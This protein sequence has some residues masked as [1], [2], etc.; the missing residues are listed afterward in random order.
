MYPK[1]KE[2]AKSKKILGYVINAVLAVLLI[3]AAV[4]LLRK[5]TIFYRPESQKPLG[6][7]AALPFL[8]RPR[9]RATAF[10]LAVHDILVLLSASS[11]ALLLTE[12][13][14]KGGIIVGNTAIWQGYIA[15]AAIFGLVY[16]FVGSIRWTTCIGMGLTLL[17]ALIDHYVTVFRGT[18]VLLSDI[19]AIGTAKNVAANYSVPV[20]LSVL[21]TLAIAVLFCVAVWRMRRAST[22]RRC[23]FITASLLLCSWLYGLQ[24]VGNSFGFWQG[25]LEYSEWYYFCRT[26]GNAIVKRP[27]GY[28]SEALT[29]ITE[30]YGG[31]KEEFRPNIIM[32]MNES[33]ADLHD[34]GDFETNEDYLPFLHSLE[35]KE[36]TITGDLLVSTFGGGTA[37]TE[38]EVLTGDTMAFLPYGSSP[39]QMYV[40]GEMPGVVSGLAAQGY[41]TV[42]LHPY[43]ATSWNRQQVYERLGFETQLYEDDFGEDDTERL[44]SYVSDRSDYYKIFEVYRYKRPDTPLFMFNVTMQNHGGY[45]PDENDNFTQTIH[46][47]GEYAGK[48][49]EVDEYLSLARESDKAIEELLA[50]FSEVD[51]PTAIIFF[52]D[53]QPN[54]PSAFYDELLGDTDGDSSGAEK[55]KKMVTP[56]FIWANYDIEEQQDV[57]ISAN[58][59]TAFALDA[60]GCSTSGYDALR[61]AVREQIPRINNAGYYLPDG[62]WTGMETVES[63]TLLAEYKM[64]QYVQLF[65]VNKRDN[66]WYEP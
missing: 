34:V 12:Y 62:S 48:Y 59:L 23:Q 40:K 51:E 57:Q 32:I 1:C 11:F 58:Y 29:R 9:K 39:Y 55:Q 44:R 27:T 64:M 10:E 16:V 2:R 56:F 21:Q 45:I 4:Y 43:L 47:T 60:L 52:G 53:H 19:F 31:T 38:F 26:A 15:H 46:L 28:S 50:Y 30:E 5:G 36:N 37:T 35:G 6:I 18:P 17:Y 3:Y 61:L 13:V 20:E 54:V 41:Q 63:G 24:L 25:N 33:F 66:A 8:L 49:P 22:P 7:L 65:D 14:V 42:S